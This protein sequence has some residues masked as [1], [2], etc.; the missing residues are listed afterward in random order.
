MNKIILRIAFVLLTIVTPYFSYDAKACVCMPSRS[1]YREFQEAR[2]VFVGKVVGSKDVASTETI[3]DQTYTSY[4]RFYQFAINETFKGLT[5][6]TTVE[7][8][9]GT[10]NTSCYQG[11]T[12][13]ESYLVYSFGESDDHL[14]SGA[15]TRTTNLSHAAAELHYLRGLLKGVPEPRVYGAVMRI[16]ADLS[17]SKP[18]TRVT[19]LAGIKV[20]IE[21]KGK[22]FE[23]VTDQHGLFSLTRIPDGN[24]K[25][26]PVLPEKYKLYFPEWA[27]FILRPQKELNYG[28]TQQGPSAY[29][30]FDVGWNNNLIGRIVDAEGNP[31]VR[32]KISVWLA[33]SPSP[34]LIRRDDYDHHA[35]GKFQFNGLNPGRYLLCAD[36]RAPF[37]DKTKAT[38]FY[39]TSADSVD[40][41]R[42]ISIGENETLESRDIQLPPGYVV[43]RIE[44]ILVWPNGVPVSGG[45]VFLSASNE[46]TEDEK[47][48]D[49]GSTDAMGR[50]SVQAFVGA[51]YWLHS[52]SDSSGKG[53]PIKVNV[54][55]LNEPLK[56]VIPFPKDNKQD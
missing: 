49:V 29:A 19:P 28:R 54:Q 8:S 3:R 51:E 50:F 32:A 55:M 34:L 9:A 17:A 4:E 25:A 52:Q 12:V 21:G 13:G 56:L 6:A 7:I 45:W 35:E 2:A 15:C 44:G 46:P 5:K 22:K 27:E 30:S 36:I 37:T 42:E 33:R 18:T 11:F 26:S 14:G 31:I 38:T 16:D 43:R 23:V 47:A 41:A 53:E 20:L 39:H 24:Y 40:Q 10:T 48:F 1:P